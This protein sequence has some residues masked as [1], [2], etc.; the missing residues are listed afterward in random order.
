M[1]T[2]M[3]ICHIIF[4]LSL[5]GLVLLQDPKGGAAGGIFGGGGGGNSL[6]GA[7][8]TTDLLTKVTRYM[9]IAFGITCLLLTI[10]LRPE[11]GSVMDSAVAAPATAPA[12]APAPVAPA[13]PGAAAPAHQEQPAPAA[14]A[15]GK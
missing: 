6:L 4:C 5:I 12:A 11:N 2:L 15:S 10:N 3:A 1:I 7:T 9:A 13:Q 14:P 8:G